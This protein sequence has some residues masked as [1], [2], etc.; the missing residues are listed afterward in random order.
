MKLIKEMKLLI[1]FMNSI[2]FLIMK[3]LEK[4]KVWKKKLKH[5]NKIIKVIFSNGKMKLKNIP[6]K[7]RKTDKKYLKFKNKLQKK[8][9]SFLKKIHK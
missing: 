9:K 3:K 8:E 2:K 6:K 5:F 7:M 1:K 4:S